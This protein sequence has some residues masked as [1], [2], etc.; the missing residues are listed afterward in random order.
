MIQWWNKWRHTHRLWCCW[1][2]VDVSGRAAAL[3]R[4]I[5]RNIMLPLRFSFFN[6]LSFKLSY[7]YILWAVL[8]N[9]GWNSFFTFPSSHETQQCHCCECSVWSGE[10]AA[11]TEREAAWCVASGIICAITCSILTLEQMSAVRLT[12]SGNC[13]LTSAL[14]VMSTSSA[15][16]WMCG[17]MCCV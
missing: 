11:W 6:G 2:D 1:R 9:P 7:F 17:N 15:L 8:E 16:Q 10:A 5:S 13:V 4:E 14:K 12:L 3:T